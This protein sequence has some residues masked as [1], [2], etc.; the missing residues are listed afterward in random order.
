[1]FPTLF[2][3]SLPE[4]MSNVMNERIRIKKNPTT[5]SQDGSNDSRADHG[6]VSRQV[7]AAMAGRPG[8]ISRSLNLICTTHPSIRNTAACEHGA[9]ILGGFSL[10]R[11]LRA[12]RAAAA[13]ISTRRTGVSRQVGVLTS[14]A[15]LVTRHG[16]A[17][18][19]KNVS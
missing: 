10:G 15:R 2:I 13:G 17:R 5:D 9:L 3:V 18:W 7:A 16:R 4:G 12:L 1:M 19:Q 14:L 6:K 11:P 8:E